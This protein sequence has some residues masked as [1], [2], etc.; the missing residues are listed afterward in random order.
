MKKVGVYKVLG[1][2][3]R[4]P[5]S[6]RSGEKV[7]DDEE[8]QQAACG[9]RIDLGDIHRKSMEVGDEWWYGLRMRRR[10]RGEGMM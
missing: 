1:R 5:I 8:K 10:E 9:C 7:D 4:D 6:Y 2:E 3:K